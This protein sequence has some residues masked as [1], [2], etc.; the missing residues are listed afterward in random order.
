MKILNISLE[1]NLFKDGSKPQQRVLG[2]SRLFE[3]FDLIVLTEKN[4]ALLKFVNMEIHPTNSFSRLFYLCDAYSL[5]KK[6]LRKYQH[7]VISAQDPFEAGF[8]AW[9]LAR[10]NNVKLQI[11]LHGD[12]FAS[13]YWRE[14]TLFNRARYYLGRWI[15]KKASS[16]RVVSQ[17]IKDSLVKLG[18]E[19]EKIIVLPIYTELLKREVNM[20]KEKEGVVFLTVGRLVKVK[21]IDLQIEAMS[22]IIKKYPATTLLIVGNGPERNNLEEKIKRSGLS[23]KIKLLDWQDDLTGFYSQAD[24]F[25]LTSNYEGWGLVVIEAASF[26]LPIIMT[27]VGC[28]GQVIK[29][30]EGGLVV[31]VGDKKALEEAMVK[32]IEDKELR[33]CLG[34]GARAAA[35]ALPGQQENWQLYKKS[36]E[37]I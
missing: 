2:Y 15:I 17:R 25:L 20:A 4:Q 30:G 6:L 18:L 12:Y 36:F 37:Q 23:E 31:T 14:E 35:A 21:N 5:G 22:Q 32:L 8:I 19:P 13:P 10:K 28:A 7:E 11:Q 29:N 26:S 27:D 33:K 9:L 34:Q 1:K 24:I 16:V 3:R